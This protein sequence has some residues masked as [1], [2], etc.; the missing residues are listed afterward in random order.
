MYTFSSEQ[1]KVHQLALSLANKH[2][3]VETDLIEVL[4]RV[5][6]M[7]INQ[8]LGVSLFIY[9]RD[10]LSLRKELAYALI[11]LARKAMIVPELK[12]AI[13][14]KTL[15]VSNASR[16]VSSLNTENAKELIHFAETHTRDEIDFEIAK[17]NPRKRCQDKMK[18]LS[19]DWVEVRMS[20]SHATFE[21]LKRAESVQAQK[22]KDATWGGVVD[23]SLEAYLDKNDPV[24]KAQR[25]SEKPKKL[26]PARVD[27]E[28][29]EYGKKSTPQNGPWTRIP[30]TAEQKHAVFLRDQGK[31]TH[32]GLDGKR[33][34]DDRWTQIH[35]I[36]HVSLGGTNDLSNLTTLC[37]RHHDLVHQLSLPIEGQV[38]W[39]RSP[40]ALY[41]VAINRLN[42][43]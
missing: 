33:C 8:I 4:Q 19:E 12:A 41:S 26:L 36:I 1:E 38:S 20:M 43:G 22:N 6:R 29:L 39:L 11:T 10:V 7:K 16:I 14:N 3:T 9:A 31:C 24:R 18:P 35:H 17:R 34:S 37:S 13:S 25:A 30:L 27:V 23:A 28:K 21:K 32:V 5:E 15:T 2:A 42:F 40:R